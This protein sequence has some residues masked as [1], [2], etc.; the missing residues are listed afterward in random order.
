[1]TENT[2]NDNTN[3]EK[4]VRQFLALPK[5]LVSLRLCYYRRYFSIVR[6]YVIDV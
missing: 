6:K 3:I 4:K 2:E 5:I 1:M